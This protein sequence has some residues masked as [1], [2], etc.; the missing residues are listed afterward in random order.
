MSWGAQEPWEGE[1]PLRVTELGS[2]PA[3]P[4]GELGCC[5]WRALRPREASF[6]EV[7]V[8]KPQLLCKARSLW[9]RSVYSPQGQPGGAPCG[10]QA[11][12]SCVEQPLS[13]YPM[14]MSKVWASEG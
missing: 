14:R 8:S 2:C 7:D 5:S 10:A 4:L 9:M 11:S 3:A 13:L 12:C 1:R 6:T